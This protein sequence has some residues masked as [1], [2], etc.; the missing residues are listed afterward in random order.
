MLKHPTLDKLQQLRLFGMYQ[1][2]CE[3]INRVVPATV[4][5]PLTTG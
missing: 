5:D 4:R 1:A 3:Q 2:L